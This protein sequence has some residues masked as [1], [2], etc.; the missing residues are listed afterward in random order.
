M[1]GPRGITLLLAGLFTAISAPRWASDRADPL[2]EQGRL[3][4]EETAGGVGCAICHGLDGTGD[5][6][7]GGVYIQGVLVSTMQS[8]LNGGVEEMDEL[9]DLSQKE[10]TAIQAYLDYLYTREASTVDPVAL[11]GKRI[12]EETAGG[13]GCAS[14][15]LEDGTGDVGP[16]IQ[17]RTA[18]EIREALGRV[19]KMAMIELTETEID[20]VAEYLGI[21][22]EASG[23]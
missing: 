22:L 1:S 2:I 7:A 6:D 20:Q 19:E 3:L 11:P 12:F 16:N 8:A 9:F 17:G 5:R 4:F 14:C 23:M 18:K 13:V 15:H 10:V 21:L